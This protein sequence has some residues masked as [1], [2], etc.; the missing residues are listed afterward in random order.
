MAEIFRGTV[1]KNKT[2][3]CNVGETVQGGG[4]RGAL[5]DGVGRGIRWRRV[6]EEIAEGGCGKKVLWV[7]G[8]IYRQENKLEA[9]Q[10][11]VVREIRKDSV[12]MEKLEE[13]GV[14]L[15]ELL[16]SKLRQ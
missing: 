7:G 8:G 6:Q 15:G 12:R 5:K 4:W 13:G 1:R 16:P 10:S 3:D 11:E 14:N 9:V 2:T